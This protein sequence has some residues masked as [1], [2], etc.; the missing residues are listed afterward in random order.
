[1]VFHTKQELEEKFQAL[2][3]LNQGSQGICFK[4]KDNLVYKLYHSYFDSDFEGIYVKK[5]ILQFKNIKLN[6]FVFPKDVIMLKKQ[7]IGDIT[8]YKNA[9]NL[10]QHNP[11]NIN[12]D[13]LSKLIYLAKKDIVSLSKQGVLCCD[14]MYNILLGYHLYIIDTLEYCFTDL[15]FRDIL[16]INLKAFNLEIMYFLVDGLFFDIIRSNPRLNK[17]YNNKGR[18]MDILEFIKEFKDTL[19]KIKGYEI[20][21]LREALDLRDSIVDDRCLK[22]QRDNE[23]MRHFFLC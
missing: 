19:A 10:Y 13:H 17:M 3:Y 7:V 8:E 20:T 21:Y 16:E 14:M 12:L 18:D 4:S 2:S 5:E 23:L 1:M 6:T 9:R 15:P 11:L 22:Y